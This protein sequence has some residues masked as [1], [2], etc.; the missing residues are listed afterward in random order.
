MVRSA[1]PTVGL[2]R[3]DRQGGASEEE[4]LKAEESWEES[5]GEVLGAHQSPK[6]RVAL[7]VFPEF[8]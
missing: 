5:D 4:P 3:S 8:I 6:E 7:A 1:D 2:Y